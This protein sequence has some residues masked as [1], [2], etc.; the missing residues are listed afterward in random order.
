MIA[1]GR[2]P[3]VLDRI[4]DGEDVGTLF[5]PHGTRLASRKHWIAYDPQPRGRLLVDEG[6]APGARS[7]KRSLLPAGIVGVGGTSSRATR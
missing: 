4:A 5:L 3:K 6:A 1:D 7:G 2:D